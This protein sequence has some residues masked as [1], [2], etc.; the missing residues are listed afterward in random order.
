M[1]VYPT[2]NIRR[3]V[4]YHIVFYNHTVHAIIDVSEICSGH[5]SCSVALHC[6]QTDCSC[7]GTDGG[8]RYIMNLQYLIVNG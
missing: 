1:Y 7:Y 6:N 8:M 2:K 4:E 5:Y 3:R